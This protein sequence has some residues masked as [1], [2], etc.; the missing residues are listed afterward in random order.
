[1]KRKL[2]HSGGRVIEKRSKSILLAEKALPLRPDGHVGQKGEG[3][4]LHCGG[5]KRNE[6]KKIR[7]RPSG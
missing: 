5:T 4:P 7:E 3:E 1:V 6:R 2:A